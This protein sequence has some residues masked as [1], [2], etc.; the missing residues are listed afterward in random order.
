MAEFAAMLREA[1][2]KLEEAKDFADSHDFGW[3]FDLG[4]DKDENGEY[5]VPTNYETSMNIYSSVEDG[6]MAST[7]EC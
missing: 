4:I 5:K 1:F 7:Q 2:K 6:W 3:Q